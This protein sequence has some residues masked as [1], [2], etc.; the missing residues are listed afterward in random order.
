[1]KTLFP[2]CPSVISNKSGAKADIHVNDGDLIKIGE[3]DKTLLVLECRATS[4]HTN[5]DYDF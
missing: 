5:G 3:S 2:D 4:G 1:M